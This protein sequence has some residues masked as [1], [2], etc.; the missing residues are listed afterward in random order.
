[1]DFTYNQTT[2]FYNLETSTICSNNNYNN[3]R[4]HSK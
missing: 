2:E 1:M 3:K 4:S